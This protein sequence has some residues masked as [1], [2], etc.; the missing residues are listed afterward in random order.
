MPT[1]EIQ[2]PSGQ[3]LEVQ[4]NTPPTEQELDEIFSAVEPKKKGVLQTAKEQF[5]QGVS[6]AEISDLNTKE[7]FGLAS[8]EDK[9][10]LKQLEGRVQVDYRNSGIANRVVGVVASQLPILGKIAGGAIKGGAVGAGIGTVAGSVAPVAG[11]AGGALTGAGI[12]AKVGV[13]YESFNIETGSMASELKR[14][15]NADGQGLDP[16]VIKGASIATGLVNAGLEFYGLSAIAK[17]FGLKNISKEVINQQIKEMAKNEATKDMFIKIG[18]DYAKGISSEGLTEAMQEV[19]NLVAGNIAKANAQGFEQIGL[20]EGV[21]QVVNA[22]IDGAIGGGVFGG[23]GSSTR[24]ANVMI[25][26]GV[27]PVEA[28]TKANTMTVYEKS[29]FIKNNYTALQQEANITPKKGETA[30][31]TNFV[32]NKIPL[33]SKELGLKIQVTSRYRENKAYKSE[34]GLGK[35]FDASMSE[36]SPENRIKITS[37]LLDDPSISFISTSDPA[38]LNAFKGNSK[39]RDFRKIDAT[40]GKKQGF[41]HINHVHVTVNPD[42]KTNIVTGELMAGEQAPQ[43]V[44]TAQEAYDLIDSVK[45]SIGKRIETVLADDP[46]QVSNLEAQLNKIAEPEIISDE[47]TTRAQDDVLTV[48]KA[49]GKNYK[50]VNP[51]LKA[52]D[53]IKEADIPDVVSMLGAETLERY[54]IDIT[55]SNADIFKSLA[56][57]AQDKKVYKSDFQLMD[58]QFTFLKSKYDKAKT[59]QQRDMA[60][61]L[62]FDKFLP[63]VPE[64]MMPAY[65]NAMNLSQYSDFYAVKT[66]GKV[67]NDTIKAFKKGL[68]EGRKT[69]LEEVK[70]VQNTVSEFIE[71]SGLAKEEKSKFFKTLKNVRTVEQMEKAL[72]EIETRIEKLIAKSEKRKVV[73]DIKKQLKQKATTKQGGVQKGKFDYETTKVYKELQTINKLSKEKAD[74]AISSIDFGD[75]E[76]FTFEE[77]LIN[78][79]YQYKSNGMDADINLLQSLL[80]DIKALKEAGRLAKDEIDFMTKVSKQ[81]NIETAI[82]KI[83]DIGKLNKV[84]KEYFK[85]IGSFSSLTRALFGDSFADKHE[86]I[87]KEIAMSVNIS[88][89]MQKVNEKAMELFGAKDNFKLADVYKDFRTPLEEAYLSGTGDLLSEQLNKFQIMDIYNS[90]KN[91]NTFDNYV[92]HYGEEQ[93]MN[94][95]DILSK[96][97]KVFADYLMETAQSYYDVYNEYSIKK[98]GLELAKQDEYWMR[99]SEFETEEN[100]LNTFVP[101]STLPSAIKKRANSVKPIPKEAF[102]KVQKHVRHAEYI[103]NIADTYEV[104]NEIF[105]N[106]DVQRAL[107]KVSGNN[108]MLNL[109]M[110]KIDKMSFLKKEEATAGFVKTIEKVLGAWSAV[111]IATPSVFLK[112]LVSSANYATVTPNWLIEFGKVIGNPKKYKEIADF[113]HEELPYLKD[114]Y[115]QGSDDLIKWILQDVDSASKYDASMLRGLTFATRKGDIGAIIFGGYPYYKYLLDS[116]MSKEEAIRKFIIQ[117][118]TTMQGKTASNLSELQTSKQ[119]SFFMRFLNA[120]YQFSR[121]VVDTQL[122]YNRG[123]ISQEQYSKIMTMYLVIQPLLFTSVGIAY[124]EGRDAIKRGVKGEDD[125]RELGEKLTDWLLEIFNQIIFTYT[126]PMPIVSGFIERLVKEG[127][128]Q[129]LKASGLTEQ[130]IYDTLDTS[131]LGDIEKSFGKF[132][133]AVK[134]GDAAP[135]VYNF[136]VLTEPAHKVPVAT[137]IR[138]IDPWTGGELKESLKNKKKKKRRKI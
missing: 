11:T 79:M 9:L 75:K 110:T 31:L 42:F 115:A 61:G 40:L 43:S 87:T 77:K 82:S 102:S 16:N 12:G 50:S 1:F 89:A 30:V 134:N 65:V 107:N 98:T 106:K 74:I 26:N 33:I 71:N 53:N 91:Q 94:L 68:R 117:T 88:K 93:I 35:A 92:K 104:W 81:K 136:A 45:D 25:K 14:E 133:T 70:Q 129:I 55:D 132:L 103:K 114:R 59:V 105:S 60:I 13:A 95:V 2:S 124:K 49:M 83:L 54:G 56:E 58:D 121:M 57:Y 37:R 76:T 7:I 39:L 18:K 5:K 17:T 62:F 38:L 73:S 8:D 24:I 99:N 47:L 116:G 36:H 48:F 101:K 111:K 23:V 46:T 19:T 118:E 123:D 4:G 69:T 78:K 72:P 15:R 97:E 108:E 44:A 113:M 109:A 10:K 122:A 112:Q 51:A 66:S 126:D 32:D 6:Q 21:S 128:N 85:N 84:L 20:K 125:D 63:S 120:P 138:E 67:V 131:A 27:K 119:L 135:A 22:G 29:Q 96:D 137:I 41:N 34:H 127:E 100:A 86:M 80:T 130:K 3:T 64:D 28:K 90:I 52:I